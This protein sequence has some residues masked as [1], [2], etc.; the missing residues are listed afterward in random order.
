M[1]TCNHRAELRSSHW[2]VCA[3]LCKLFYK[4]STGL[5]LT[6]SSPVQ[7]HVYGLYVQVRLSRPHEAAALYAEAAN[8]MSKIDTGGEEACTLI[9]W[10]QLS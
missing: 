10:A 5:L 2:Q 3:S 8:A 9:A 4:G 1:W 7:A 6:A